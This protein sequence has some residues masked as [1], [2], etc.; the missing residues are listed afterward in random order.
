MA[1]SNRIKSPGLCFKSGLFYVLFTFLI[2]S[3]AS[4]IKAQPYNLSEACT[5]AYHNILDLELTKARQLL[6]KESRQNEANLMPILFANYADFVEIFTTN[7]QSLYNDYYSN[8]EARLNQIQKQ[9]NEN[10]AYHRY[11]QAEILLQW[12]FL[13]MKKG[14]YLTAL[15]DFRKAYVLLMNNHTLYP[16]FMPTKK[17]LGILQILIGAVPDQYQ[18]AINL[19]GVKGDIDEG[20]AKLENTIEYG[21]ENEFLFNDETV[22]YYSAILLHI[23]QDDQKA[24][25]VIR[26]ANFPDT[27][28]LLTSFA[29]GN[30]ALF[31]QHNDKAMKWLGDSRHE[32]TK[33]Q[34]PYLNFLYGKAKL[35]KLAQDADAPFHTFLKEHKGRDH[36]KEA[37]QKIAWHHLLKEDTSSYKHY[38]S[39]AGN[40]GRTVVDGDKQAQREVE[41]DITPH[42]VLLKARLLSDGGYYKRADSLLINY[43]IEDFTIQ[44]Q[45][46]E[47]SYRQGRIF[48]EWGKNNKA[49]PY[50]KQ[51]IQRGKEKPYYY[52]ANAA[53]QLGYIYQSKGD[54]ELALKYFQQCQDMKGH[55]YKNS[56]NQKAKAAIEGLKDAKH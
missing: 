53:L 45:R 38:L 27:S 3:P 17:S 56:I 55:P 1:T 4:S 54:K 18:W 6:L 23:I 52:A 36:I 47:F 25:Q 43:A 37:W 5:A 26:N 31:T 49:I 20:L 12:A 16:D 33:K 7:K 30:T 11:I 34:F 39:K 2:V 13:E 24:W 46:L 41:R 14:D 32:A 40:Q 21:Q 51:T 19:V 9:G 8:K 22:V 42:S 48:D 15:W 28:R 50:Y 44:K 29:A 10:S 35:Q